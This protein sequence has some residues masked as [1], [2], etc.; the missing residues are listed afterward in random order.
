[1]KKKIFIDV[2]HG[3][4]DS[5]G[6]KGKIKEK[7]INL[8]V[9]LKLAEI[10]VKH[11]FEVKLSRTS[12]VYLSLTERCRMANNWGADI[13]ICIHH[14][15]GGGDGFSLIHSIYRGK[16]EELSKCIATQFKAMGQNPHGVGIYSRKSK[17]GNYDY[18]T[19]INKTIA[20]AIITEFGFIDT[21]DVEIFDTTSELH[22][23]ATAIAK[24]VCDY[25]NVDY[26]EDRP[27]II[28]EILVLQSD[29]NKLGYVGSN[30]IELTEDGIY[31][32]NTKYAIIQLQKTIGLIVDGVAN[33]ETLKVVKCILRYLN[34]RDD[35]E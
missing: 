13:F 4:N 8:I 18:Y 1:M 26:K 14:N 19:V 2:G 28:N 5:G 9:A 29:L 11:G 34:W 35:Y 33:T 7:L 15:A 17:Q 23:E 30:G 16:G 32:K 10:L 6:C 27:I 25:Y 21:D 31:G 22:N 3:G 24:G 20:P 12:D